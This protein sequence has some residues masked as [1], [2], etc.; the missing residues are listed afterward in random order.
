MN[1]IDFNPAH[2]CDGHH[3]CFTSFSFHCHLMKENKNKATSV[4]SILWLERACHFLYD[5]LKKCSA[6]TCTMC[7]CP[8]DKISSVA[9]RREQANA[10]CDT[11]CC[12]SFGLWKSDYFIL[13]FSIF[14]TRGGELYT[15]YTL[16]RVCREKKTTT[17][18]DGDVL[19]CHTLRLRSSSWRAFED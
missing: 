14:H 9:L 13:S 12:L 8:Y 6:G 19:W 5:R 3:V 16:L 15:V 11:H 2:C 10:D 18:G 7:A 1:N 4:V 17:G